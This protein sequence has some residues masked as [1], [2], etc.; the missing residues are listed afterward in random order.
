[1]PLPRILAGPIVRRVQ[2]RGCSF[3]VVLSVPATVKALIW[4]GR[5]D[6]G[7]SNALTALAEGELHT[8]R[9]GNNLHVAVVTVDL[10]AAPNPLDPGELYS[11]N[12]R[13]AFD[14]GGTSDLHG[15][16]L[17]DFEVV[18]SRIDNVDQGA[19][20]HLPLGFEKDKLPTFLVPPMKLATQATS[21]PDAGLRLAHASCRRAGAASFDALAGLA[22]VVQ[23][24]DQR[25]HQLYLTGDQIYADDVAT[26][27]LPVIAALGDELLGGAQPLPGFPPDRR[28]GGSG[29]TPVTSAG[30][31]GNLAN[32]PPMRRKWLLWELARFTGG[33]VENHLITFSEF[34]AHH[35][36]A[37]SPRVWR[38]IPPFQETFKAPGSAAGT[39]APAAGI[40]PWLN[41]PWFCFNGVDPTQPEATVKQSWGDPTANKAGFEGYNRSAH[42]VARYAGGTPFV[43]QV[44]ANTPTC[45]MFDDHEIADD[46]NLNGRWFATVYARAWGRFIIR[47]GL[48]AFALMQGWGNDPA[49]FV[50]ST[51]GA[52]LLEQI[53]VVGAAG[54]PPPP[55]TVTSIDILL[56]FDTTTADVP[57][58]VEWSFS[59]GTED[60]QAVV[61]DTRTHRELRSTSLDPPNL[62]DNLDDQL[63]AATPTST[64]PHL[65]LVSPV[66]VFGPV[67]IEQ[68]GQPASIAA[69]DIASAFDRGEIPGFAV[70]DADHPEK[71]AGCGPRANERGIEKYDR[72][73]WT[74]N[75]KGFEDLLARLVGF[76][77]VVLLSGDVH[78]A[79]TLSLDYWAKERDDKPIRIVQCT[80]SPAKNVFKDVVEQLV[81]QVA[82]LQHAEEVKLERLAW[83]KITA[84]DLGLAGTRL[85][86]ARRARLRREPALLTTSGWPSNASIPAGKQ[87]DWRWR[88]QLVVDN[89]TTLPPSLQPR[90]MEP[91]TDAKDDP[92]RLTS[93]ASVH[94]TRLDE[95]KP[96]LRRIVFAP[97]FGV[98]S[99][100]SDGAEVTATHTI[101][102]PTQP[103]LPPAAADSEPLPSGPLTRQ[104]ATF[105]PHT[106]HHSPLTTPAAEKIP[107]ISKVS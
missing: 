6:V 5:L 54:T 91:G 57:K 62:V 83:K 27:F 2:V 94:R 92:A 10:T 95:A 81:R 97:N 11:Y 103:S 64:A 49:K 25:P 1:M 99:F 12:L 87:P 15:E 85:S 73:G 45:M 80:S 100:S 47:N 18:G 32:L 104:A 20:L 41:R 19:P 53:A 34:V 43:A 72:E 84:A 75:E 14:A 40:N 68:I 26:P 61:L 78:Y 48:M 30:L 55:A 31:P 24:P 59:S 21:S 4:K 16:K 76:Q 82:N 33:D 13:F 38:T 23:D 71:R 86:L 93:I 63:P 102:T 28:E 9:I 74:A 35:L 44:L 69:Q 39:P 46:W 3:W 77:K 17:L 52:E 8:K 42:H 88:I 29:D 70:G 107:T 56:G 90:S 7:G 89:T 101:Y 96:M 58:R 36:L 65:I 37:W 51:P 67:V 105:G 98:V 50:S 79:T 66:P 22:A 106:V 60:Y